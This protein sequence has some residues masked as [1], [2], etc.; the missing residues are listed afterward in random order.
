MVHQIAAQY[1][2]VQLTCFIFPVISCSLRVFIKIKIIIFQYTKPD[3]TNHG[4]EKYEGTT[5]LLLCSACSGSA[6][7][8]LL[9]RIIESH[10]PVAHQLLCGVKQT[11]LNK[12]AIV[13]CI[14]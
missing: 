14:A 13:F 11:V 1:L 4:Y 7:T 10:Q 5:W 12:Y 9:E 8:S 3:G 2:I 6:D